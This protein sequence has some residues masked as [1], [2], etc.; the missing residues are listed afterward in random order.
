MRV[1][2][3]RPLAEPAHELRILDAAGADELRVDA[4]RGEPG[5]RVDLI[6]QYAVTLDEEVD[7]RESL[8]AGEFEGPQRRLAHAAGERLRDRGG[9]RQAHAPR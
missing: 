7:S 6:E 8:A 2:F 9:N 4:E 1:A 5:H 3:Q